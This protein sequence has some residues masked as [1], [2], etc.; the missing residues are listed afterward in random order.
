MGVVSTEI[1]DSTLQL[2]FAGWSKV[3]GN[4]EIIHYYTFISNQQGRTCHGG[5]L[6]I[7]SIVYMFFFKNKIKSSDKT[8]T[9]NLKHFTVKPKVYK[10]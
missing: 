8:I 10:S 9:H 1:V 5:F 4:L 3:E 7:L 2:R 6:E